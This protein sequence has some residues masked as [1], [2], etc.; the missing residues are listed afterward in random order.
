MSDNRLN[1]AAFLEL[2]QSLAEA[3]FSWETSAA[4]ELLAAL[5]ATYEPL[6]EGSRPTCCCRCRAGL[7]RTTIA[8][9]GCAVRAV[10]SHDTWLRN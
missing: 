9:T 6:L 10:S 8:I 2:E 1:H 4:E 5:R 3:G 7:P